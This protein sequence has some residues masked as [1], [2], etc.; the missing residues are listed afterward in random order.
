M[1]KIANDFTSGACDFTDSAPASE[2]KQPAKKRK[3][4][5]PEKCTVQQNVS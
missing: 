1:E 5:K 2:V 3:T 4:T